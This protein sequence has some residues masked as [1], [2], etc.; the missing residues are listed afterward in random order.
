MNGKKAKA[1]RRMAEEVGEGKPERGVVH[2]RVGGSRVRLNHG[3]TV[4]GIYRK[5]KDMR[6]EGLSK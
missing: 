1:L 5:L 2:N 6:K 4:R 3:G